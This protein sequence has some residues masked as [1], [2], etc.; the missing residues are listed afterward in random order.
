[1]NTHARFEDNIGAIISSNEW[2]C[3]LMT[4]LEIA[5]TLHVPVSWIYESTRRCGAERIPHIKLGKYL[6]FEI[7]AVRKWPNSL[8]SHSS[9]RSLPQRYR[10]VGPF[11]RSTSRHP[12][13]LASAIQEV[14]KLAQ[15][16]R[17][18]MQAPDSSHGGEHAASH[19]FPSSCDIVAWT[20]R[21][22]SFPSSQ[23][24]YAA[25]FRRRTESGR[26]A[27]SIRLKTAKPTAASAC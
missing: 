1:M 21:R 3:E 26:T 10:N 16:K 11:F 12:W 15:A 8:S 9:V 5:R 18:V 14:P 24:V 20:E 22:P 7:A 19:V 17:F 2:N 4:V 25:M 6:R 23:P 13:L 27:S